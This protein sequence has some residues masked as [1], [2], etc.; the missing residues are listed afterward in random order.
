MNASEALEDMVLVVDSGRSLNRAE[1]RIEKTE[2]RVRAFFAG[3]AVADSK[4]ALL[5]FEPRRLPVYYLPAADVRM[6]LLKP[7]RHTQDSDGTSETLRWDLTLAGRTA[8][9]A[10]WG[11]RE[12]EGERAALR[13]HVAFYWNRLDA[14]F[15]EDDEVFV[16]PR[17]PYHRVDVL[18]S[19]RHVK[20]VVDGEVIADTERPRLLFETGLPTRYYIPKLDVRMDLLEPTDKL[21]MCPYKGQAHYWSVRVA[22]KVLGDL[23][24]SY[25]VAIAECPK[26]ENLLSFYNE[27]VDIYVDGEL[28]S[29]PKTNWS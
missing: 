6:D 29:R 19:S 9:N 22:D 8:E 20:V 11:F 28:Q 1:L 18:N 16:H 21:T 23:V 14:W 3:E 13:D 7:T 15:E 17:D 24:W 10:A 12:P 5:V 27:K 4:N 26:I 2:R 25:P